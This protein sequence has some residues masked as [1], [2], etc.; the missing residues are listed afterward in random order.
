M[1]EKRYIASIDLVSRIL[2]PLQRSLDEAMGTMGRGL[3]PHRLA[4]AEKQQDRSSIRTPGT[5]SHVETASFANDRPKPTST[6]PLTR[7]KLLDSRKSKNQMVTT[8]K[9]AFGTA[10]TIEAKTVPSRVPPE[11]P[12]GIDQIGSPKKR[13]TP[14]PG[15]VHRS[16]K[17]VSGLPREAF[18]KTVPAQSVAGIEPS[19][20]AAIRPDRAEPLSATSASGQRNGQ[21]VEA[22]A[23]STQVPRA[24]SVPVADST[25]PDEIERA[26]KVQSWPE[27]APQPEIAQ[28]RSP[29]VPVQ[30][31]PVSRSDASESIGPTIQRQV[32]ETHPE[33]TQ[34]SGRGPTVT[35]AG[36][37]APQREEAARIIPMARPLRRAAGHVA[38]GMEPAL[39]QAYA[40][41]RESLEAGPEPATERADSAPV[42]RV[43]NTFNVNVS[44]STDQGLTAEQREALKDTLIDIL[45]SAAR[46]HGLEV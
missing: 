29:G 7:R 39:D 12:P 37:P 21:P 30:S 16:D 3:D 42:S 45:S 22:P 35:R 5:L 23:Y 15:S 10:L 41:T 1:P 6:G 44:M 19:Q 43:S 40:V 11:T 18:Q 2:N 8:T 34:A 17:T 27:K 36:I 38:A 46:R 33:P 4:Q 13:E 9:E 31:R 25:G 20:K 32:P 26:E 28:K 14:L 24:T